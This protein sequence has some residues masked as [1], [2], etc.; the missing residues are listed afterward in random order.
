MRYGRWSLVVLLLASGCQGGRGDSAPD[1]S[2]SAVASVPDDEAMLPGGATAEASAAPSEAPPEVPAA[3]GRSVDVSNELY[4]FSY[5]Y[6]DAAGAIP[7]FRDLLDAQLHAARERLESSARDD[8]NAA[9]KDG[10][11]YHQHS[12]GAKWEVVTDLPG[13]LSLSAKIYTYTGGAHGMSAFNSLLWD[14]RGEAVRKPR[15]LFTSTDALRN[16][17]REPFCDALDKQREKR[18]GEPVQRDSGQMFS[19]CID[20]VAQTLILGSSNR[21]TFDRIGILVGP[22]E[23]GPYAEG[24]Y[25]V[26]LPVTG[27]VMAT[28]KPQYRTGFSVGQ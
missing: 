3:T 6:P 12:Y 1:G 17:I 15:D 10:F 25:E 5:S 20:P 27:A 28:L 19:E 14:R 22:Y 9:Q 4:E 16:A 26:T 13:W 7:G 24:T 21:K 2:A 23:A 11:P 8:R 18:R